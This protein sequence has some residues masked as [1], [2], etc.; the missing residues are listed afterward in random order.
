MPC[1]RPLKGYRSRTLTESGKRSV[2]F[3]PR[4]GFLDMPIN[5]PCG[6]CIGCRLERS[7]QWA[8]RCVHEASLYDK[9]CF[10]TLTYDGQHLPSDG[11]LD[12]KHFQDFMKRLRFHYGN[13]IRFFHAGE[14]GERFGRPHYHACVFNHDF[15]DKELFSERG[16]FKLYSS[17][18]LSEIWGKGFCTIGE[19]NFE[20]AAY[21]ARYVTKKVTGRQA[22]GHYKGLKPEYTTM[23]RRPGIARGWFDLYSK[24]VFPSDSVVVRGRAMRPPK[25]YDRVFELANPEDF[26]FVKAR[27]RVIGKGFREKCPETRLA[28][29]ERCHELKFKKLKRGYENE[30]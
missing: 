6:Q 28:V 13:G 24:D 17:A 16:G 20:T 27:R 4:E 3:N 21:V 9:N 8:M 22:E 2:V 14:Y 15:D 26:R 23:S 11:S 25:F 18:A 12:V 1:Y 5:L 7:R 19:V 10:L 30:T 29:I